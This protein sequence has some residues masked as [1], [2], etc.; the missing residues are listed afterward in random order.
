[1]E[2]KMGGDEDEEGDGKERREEE[3]SGW[4]TNKKERA[5]DPLLLVR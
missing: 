4:Q 5:R 3:D 2:M 1:M